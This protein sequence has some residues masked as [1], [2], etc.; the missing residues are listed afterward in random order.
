VC[1]PHHILTTWMKPW[2]FIE[3]LAQNKAVHMQ[4]S[5][6]LSFQLRQ[7]PRGYTVGT[8]VGFYVAVM[9]ALVP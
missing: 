3:L 5:L 8:I 6:H 9:E 1:M 4:L 7:S 2:G